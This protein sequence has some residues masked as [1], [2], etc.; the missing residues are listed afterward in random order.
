VL[1]PVL[2]AL[3]GLMLLT[4]FWLKEALILTWLF[5]LIFDIMI[6]QAYFRDWMSP[7]VASIPQIRVRLMATMIENFLLPHC[8]F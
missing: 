3:L 1:I 8:R 2:E 5:Y 6:L 7:A 4:R